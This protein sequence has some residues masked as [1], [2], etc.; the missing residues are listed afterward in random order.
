[1]GD[2]VSLATIQNFVATDNPRLYGDTVAS[3]VRKRVFTD[4]FPKGTLENN[5]GTSFRINVAER[6]V[7]ASSLVK[8]TFTAD[9]SMCR[10]VPGLDRYGS[11]EYTMALGTLQGRSGPVCVKQ[12]KT[13]F[14]SAYKQVA[15][16]LKNGIGDLVN[17]EGRAQALYFSGSKATTIST[18]TFASNFAGSIGSIAQPFPSLVAN[19]A[20]TGYPDSPPS[21]KFIKQIA[22][23]LLDV[24][25]VEPFEMDR[26]STMIKCIFEN[27]VTDRLRDEA[28]IRADMRAM[29]T[30]R[31]SLG[32]KSLTGFTYEGP[33]QGIGF[34]VDPQPLRVVQ[35]ADG[36]ALSPTVAPFTIDWVPGHAPAD[37]TAGTT[38][39]LLAFVEPE[40]AVVVTNGFGARPNPAWVSAPYGVGFVTG[41]RSFWRLTPQRYNG[42]GE[43]LSFPEQIGLETLQWDVIRD[44]D[45]N[46]FGQTGDWIYEISRAYEPESPHAICAVLYKRCLT[47]NQGLTPCT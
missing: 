10:N 23:Y 33:Y 22:N 43:G 19:V 40:I 35:V 30:G 2:C 18:N 39:K 16:S 32:E 4:I 13:A 42:N 27:D 45:C 47:G 11:R 7:L 38:T 29:L 15:N 28:D 46:R 9:V 34:A 12:A 20:G 21:F 31:Y 41:D 5:Q 17:A 6:A 1:M 44:N 37:V 8:P 3:I 14:L 36:G 25:G 24:L 26:G